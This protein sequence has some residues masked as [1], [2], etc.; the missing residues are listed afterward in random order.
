M[1]SF[2]V[3]GYC[4]LEACSFLKEHNGAVGEGRR[5]DL[6]RIKGGEIVW[7]VLM[8]EEF[9]L[10]KNKANEEEPKVLDIS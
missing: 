6:G 5:L 1:F 9:I 4:L 10:S 2:V 3:L 8:T 7:N